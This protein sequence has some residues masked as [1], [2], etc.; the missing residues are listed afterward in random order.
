MDHKTLFDA[1]HDQQPVFLTLDE[2]AQN[3]RSFNAGGEDGFSPAVFRSLGASEE[4]LSELSG[5]ATLRSIRGASDDLWTSDAD[6]SP[7]SS[8]DLSV[9]SG[10]GLMMAAY[11]PVSPKPDVPVE[12]EYVEPW[13]SFGT[14][15]P[16]ILS[17]IYELLLAAGVECSYNQAKHKIKGK[18]QCPNDTTGK[19]S[20]FLYQAAGGKRFT[21]E[22]VRRSGD[23]L[24]FMAV[25][26]QLQAAAGDGASGL[27]D[28]AAL[29]PLDALP[30]LELAL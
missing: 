28:F 23:V 11:S 2:E 20:I 13:S 16:A 25:F 8:K 5:P 30:S 12:P 26:K 29:P 14:L 3:F 21:V 1:Q 22:C 19:F 24:V 10:K 18:F 17:I 15:N 4:G 7:S 6:A 9:P 27:P